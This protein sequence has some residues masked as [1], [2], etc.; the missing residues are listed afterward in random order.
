[1]RPPWVE[2]IQALLF[3]QEGALW[4]A[5][6]HEGLL[7]YQN[8]QVSRLRAQD[9]V[10]TDHFTSL[11]ED[12][13]GS[14]WAGT[15]F[16]GIHRM[17]RGAIRTYGTGEGL[18]ADA[19]T[20]VLE[21][22]PGVLWIGTRTE[23]LFKY[24]DGRFEPSRP[25]PMSREI[26]ALLLA[27]DGSVWY[28]GKEGG[29]ACVK[30]E[31][32]SIFN[33]KNGLIA[34]DVSALYQA[35]S[36]ELWVGSQRAGVT[37][38]DP[39][40]RKVK[41][42]YNDLSL[43]G[44]VRCFAEDREG[45]LWIG[46]QNGLVRY[47]DGRFEPNCLKGYEDAS[48]RAILCDENNVLWVGTRDDG[49]IR[50]SRGEVFPFDFHTGVVHSRIYQL[51]PVGGD[52]WIA[53][54]Q[55][56]EHVTFADL[57]EVAEGRSPRLVS[58]VYTEKDGLRTTEC[59][60]DASPSAAL[61]RDGTLWF[62]TRRGLA[63]LDPTAAVN[64]SPAPHAVIT[65]VRLDRQEVS[66]KK[67][68]NV[69]PGTT[70]LQISYGAPDL[71]HGGDIQYRYQLDSVDKQ[72]I[73]AGK[74]R[75]A[76]Y[77]SLRPG[78]YTFSVRAS[79]PD[80]KWGT[81]RT[82]LAFTVQPRVYQ[83][84]WFIWGAAL[85]AT[86][87]IYSLYR[88]SVSGI[89]RRNAKLQQ[90]VRDRTGELEE[91]I[92]HRKAA[93]EQQL[94]L[95]LDLESR[96]SARTSELSG[97]YENLQEELRERERIE[98]ELAAS[99]S[100]LRRVVDS[101][102]VGILFWRKDGLVLDAND[103]FL[104]MVGYSRQDLGRGELCWSRITPPEYRP[105][106]MVALQEIERTGVCTPF[107]KEY[108]R[109]NGS[110]FPVLIGGASVDQLREEGVC[111]VLDISQRK[112]SEEEV[113]RLAQSLEARVQERTLELARTNEQLA[114]EVQERKRV[115]IA[116]TELSQ[117]GQK[118]HSAR[119]ENEAAKIIAETAKSL[120]A[121]DLCTI[122]LYGP[123][124][125]LYPVIR[126][127][128]TNA[129]ADVEAAGPMRSSVS[130]TIR[131]GSRVIG[132]IG[133]QSST[134]DSLN[135]ADA[136]SLQALGDYCGGAL[137]RI[138]AEEARRETER[139]F[140]A[141]MANAPALAWMK[142]ARLRY[143]FSNPMFQEFLGRSAEQIEE[144]TDDELWPES[145]A[146]R[147][148]GNDLRVLKSEQTIETQETL[149]RADEET[150]TLLTLRFPFTTASGERFV[151]GMAVDITEQKQA[152]EVLRRLPQSILEAQEQER[153]RLARELHDSVN[154]AIASAK[155][156]IQTAENQITRGDPKW[157]ESS[158][159]SKEMLDLVLQQVRR[160]SHNLR[161][162][163]LDDLGLLPA[164]RTAFR[165]F[166]DRTGT[167]IQFAA[168]GF[169]KRLEP[170]LE[171]TLYRIIQEALTNI[172]KHSSA[173]SVDV[174]LTENANGITLE[175]TDNGI[176]IDP[177]HATRLREGLGLIHMRERASLVGGTF[178]LETAP[179]QGVRL[180]IQVPT[181][182]RGSACIESHA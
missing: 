68:V 88:W 75:E 28:G 25:P 81:E 58:R 165:E 142:D 182:F 154:Q 27:K 91:E 72:W 152:E 21:N 111:F 123:D 169:E 117:L 146:A 160:L 143:V 114:M 164:A 49:L 65:K 73:E 26:R 38:L 4:V 161:P 64:L 118:L 19:I 153:R 129:G 134:P 7:R 103:T 13:E 136:S 96:V 108:I 178:S 48:I 107:E 52:L 55:G 94:A 119:T 35:R 148:R 82:T 139:R 30:D 95:N 36:G 168:V 138:H 63:A 41:R 89:Q 180:R 102:M 132:V 109:A 167:V 101:G 57:N 67:F 51:L 110:R 105:L 158:R 44:H 6:Q 20:C 135:Y 70:R 12:R 144:K 61:A 163:E 31:Q 39:D 62:G 140:S 99:E 116:L 125:R 86:G 34:N 80:G 145:T 85:A 92:V 133:V 60:S 112:T 172:E 76:V 162:G 37:V 66:P 156:R 176:G 71:R 87:G 104:Q 15:L 18:E 84:T 149:R 175:L 120:I 83:T 10:V 121:H 159:K 181:V 23:G 141:F 150:R 100:R 45:V 78:H 147:I 115:A 171:S 124:D 90:L 166:E 33:L 77:Y 46:T 122:Q 137:D 97:A 5:T 17:Y 8:G 54:N 79:N 174:Q 155:F 29:L 53:G 151:A 22:G 16:G 32:Q 43:R 130:V 113:R 177:A 14:I 131:N 106:D 127:S 170:T 56:I 47:R 2:N 69:P 3:D 74:E 24:V 40:A 93:E 179:G 59:G 1:M 11:F 98:A 157:Q 173:T 42:T 126:R 128:T 50:V 9:G